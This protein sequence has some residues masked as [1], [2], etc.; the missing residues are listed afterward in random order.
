MVLGNLMND[1]TSEIRPTIDLKSWFDN[2]ASH[3]PNI[4]SDIYHLNSNSR[5]GMPI[6]WNSREEV[7]IFFI[8]GALLND[9]GG[10]LVAK[11]GYIRNRLANLR[12]HDFSICAESHKLKFEEVLKKLDEKFGKYHSQTRPRNML[13]KWWS[14]TKVENNYDLDKAGYAIVREIYDWSYIGKTGN[15]LKIL[16][17]KS[18]WIARELKIHG[19]W[20][21]IPNKY[22]CIPDSIVRRNLMIYLRQKK[23]F[24]GNEREFSKA[25]SHFD[26]SRLV[27]QIIESFIESQAIDTVFPFDLPFFKLSLSY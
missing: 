24:E 5:L 1:S 6:E 16:P 26:I 21:D 9:K 27:S 14:E 3:S 11:A 18:F 23:V 2:Q 8:L 7:F 19:I 12:R 10:N 25:F 4:Y 13:I 22:C 15:V 17:V 20:P